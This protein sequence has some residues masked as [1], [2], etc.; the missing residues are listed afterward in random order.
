MNFD[1]M[2]DDMADGFTPSEPHNKTEISS[3][4]IEKMLDEMIDKKLASLLPNTSET[5][6]KESATGNNA[7]ESQPQTETQPQTDDT[8]TT[9]TKIYNIQK[10]EVK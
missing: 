10:D 7:S 3:D 1:K 6:E 9:D 4:A 5:R 8:D 2:L